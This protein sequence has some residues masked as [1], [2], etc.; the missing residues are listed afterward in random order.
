MNDLNKLR[1]P[2]CADIPSMADRTGWDNLDIAVRN[3][4][5]DRRLWIDAIKQCHFGRSLRF[6]R[7][8]QYWKEQID[9]DLCGV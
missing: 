9:K 7:L 5:I 2:H 3:E 1:Y 8:A 4:A 6:C